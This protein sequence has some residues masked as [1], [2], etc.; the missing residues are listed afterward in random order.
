M[1]SF[2]SKLNPNQYREASELLAKAFCY[3]PVIFS[4]LQGLPPRK[5]LSR[6]KLVFEL[7]LKTIGPKRL[8]L[9][10]QKGNEIY[11]VALLHPPKT[12]PPSFFSYFYILIN[13]IMR[14][15]FYGLSKWLIW[16]QSIKKNHPKD[17]HFYL[18]FIGVDPLLQ[19]KGIGSLI[20]TKIVS[21]A[22]KAFMS[23]YLETANP[24]NLKFYNRFVFEIVGQEKIIGVPTWFMERPPTPFPNQNIV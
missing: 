2:I 13:A 7:T 24:Q 3:D 18:E 22:D 12:Y 14:K 19:R 23:C 11:G 9:S 8:V 5:R 17:L 4:I 16:N 6:I 10:A 15:G 21:L 20:L 1:D